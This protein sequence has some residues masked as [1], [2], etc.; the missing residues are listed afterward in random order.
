VVTSTTQQVPGGLSSCVPQVPSGSTVSC[1][2]LFEALK[3][4]KRME[5]AYSSFGRF[6]IDDR[7]WGDLVAGTALEFPVPYQEMQ[8]RQKG[9]YNLG[10]G[11]G[12]SSP[13]G[14]YGF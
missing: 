5:T 3:Y 4:E 7:G 11:F 12:S 1:G 10:G 14:T 2:T 8:S 6:W 9:S 13:K